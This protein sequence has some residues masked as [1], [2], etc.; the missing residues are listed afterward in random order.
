[1]VKLLGERGG[2]ICALSRE[3]T[4]VNL[5][6][7]LEALSPS[8]LVWLYLP[9][10]RAHPAAAS[11]PVGTASNPQRIDIVSRATA[12][13]NLRTSDEFGCIVAAGREGGSP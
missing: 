2:K 1:M 10:L 11:P 9:S 4:C 13:N 5:R 12:I 8:G 3:Q 7:S 6:W